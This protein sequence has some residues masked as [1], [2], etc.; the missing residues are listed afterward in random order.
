VS[1]T[2]VVL[3]AVHVVVAAV[4]ASW[5]Y[6]RRNS[7]RAASAFAALIAAEGLWSLGH[8]GE[9]L[10][11][12]LDGKVAFDALQNLPPAVIGVSSL[13]LA[14]EYVGVR[15]GRTVLYVVGVLSGVC[16]LVLASGA[17]HLHHHAHEELVGSP[18]VLVYEF[19][20]W[21]FALCALA[22]GGSAVAA[23]IVLR[24]FVG[25]N[26]MYAAQSAALSIALALPAVGTMFV[27]SMNLTIDG[28]RDVTPITFTSGAVIAAWGLRRRLFDVAPIARDAVLARLPDPVM[29]FD[30]DLR[31]VDANPAAVTLIG[32]P[33]PELLA[34]APEDV[35]RRFPALVALLRGEA[36]NEVEIAADDRWYAAVSTPIAD[37]RGRPI[38]HALMLREV[39]ARK[40]VNAQLEASVEARTAELVVSEKRFRALFDEI[41]SLVGLLDRD[42]R[43][44]AVNRAAFEMVGM[45]ED[46]LRGMPFWDTPWWTHDPAV[47][48]QIRDAIA[49]AAEGEAVRLQTYHVDRDGK[50]H[51]IDFSLTPVRDARGEVVELIP[52]GRDVT[53]LHEERARAE[54]LTE[55]L[56]QGQKLESVGR[57]AG[58]IAHDFNNLL[59]VIRV[60]TD[61]LREG[62]AAGSAGLTSVNEIGEAA[63]AAAQITRQ[64]LTFSRNQP[65]ALRPVTMNHALAPSRRLLGR[66]LRADVE[67]R[68]DIGPELWV[69]ADPTQLQQVVMNLA[70]NAQ[71]AMP[72]GGRLVIAIDDVVL[73]ELAA[74]E[75]VGARPG[76]HVRLT[77]ADTGTGMDEVTRARL[78]EP[79]Y[80]T[81]PEGK[82]TGLGLAVVYGAVYQAGGAIDVT[83][84]PGDGTTF[85]LYFPRVDAPQAAEP[86]PA[87]VHAPEITATRTIVLVEDQEALR[88][89]ISRHLKRCGYTLHVFGSPEELRARATALDPPPD[90]LLSDVV[91]PGMNGVELARAVAPL[92]PGVRVL[93]MSGY[94]ADVSVSAMQSVTEDMLISKPFRPA[95]LVERIE[96][97]LRSAP[98]WEHAS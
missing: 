16:A 25:E 61:E 56:R 45:R 41:V 84:R 68:F 40:R 54:R 38:G 89:A 47:Q 27:M 95:D 81:K 49:R 77:V 21:D 8:L 7:V 91:L 28:D 50:R 52:E 83:S 31:L 85:A 59:T 36:D 5:S 76:R 53:A 2:L 55:Q 44:L 86:A 62:Q 73:D 1:Q 48:A 71:D 10:S 33:V 22:L 82:G 9:T 15:R 72:D 75:I 92:W 94:T 46:A 93:F 57:L 4:I 39:T 35:L 65:A 26:A 18:A 74:G 80:T 63:D 64:L 97:S 58:G 12:T 30:R 88:Q 79:F 3:C 78:F 17:V 51:E 29:V 96:Q 32:E 11:T 66:L 6:R 34:R 13:W 60:N 87:P 69:R 90:L 14:Y 42:G 37:G 67:L 43:V 20:F 24:R 23:I 19:G 98:A 70:L